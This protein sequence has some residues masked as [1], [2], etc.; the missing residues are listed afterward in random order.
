MISKKVKRKKKRKLRKNNFFLGFA[1]NS[2]NKKL[3]SFVVSS[4]FESNLK[5]INLI[6]LLWKFRSYI[7]HPQS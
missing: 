2:T 6:I 4:T 7:S 1:V 5:S 3:T